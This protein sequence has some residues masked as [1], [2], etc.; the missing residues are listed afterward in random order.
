M[1]RLAL[2]LGLILLSGPTSAKEITETLSKPIRA[3]LNSNLPP[4][5]IELCVADAITTIGGAIPIPIRNGEKD[6][7]ILGYGHTPKIIV[8]L[9]AVDSGTRIEIR[10]KSGDMDEK[11]AQNIKSSCSIK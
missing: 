4:S 2:C 5:H 9:S 10:T 3:T 1:Y 7:M 11:L 6:V 8:S